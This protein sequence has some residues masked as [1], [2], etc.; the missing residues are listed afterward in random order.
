[1]QL[2]RTALVLSALACAAVSGCASKPSV[3]APRAAVVVE[4]R[5]P[6]N[7]FEKTL[8]A[9]QS[10]Q[11]AVFGGLMRHVDN[12]G[13]L[14]PRSVGPQVG[15]LVEDGKAGVDDACT[16]YVTIRYESDRRNTRVNVRCGAI[17]TPGQR[18]MVVF[19]PGQTDVRDAIRLVAAE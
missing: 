6:A 18:V 9:M 19:T 16:Q 8:A 14:N 17:Y 7:G 5:N 15:G 3:P 11:A 13:S 10:G 2:W 12:G 1:M 4:Q